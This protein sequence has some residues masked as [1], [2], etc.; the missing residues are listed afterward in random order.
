M[1]IGEVKGATRTVGEG[2]GCRGLPIRDEP[3]NCAVN[4]PGTPS[5]VT[6]WLPGPEELAALNRG[7]PIHVRILGSA[8]PPMLVEVGEIP[9]DNEGNDGKTTVDRRAASV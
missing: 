2:Q 8:P 7:A 3:F 4:G 9:S 5:M 1:E 6:A